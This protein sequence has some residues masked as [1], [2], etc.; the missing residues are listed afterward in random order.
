M[1]RLVLALVLASCAAPQKK[2]EAAPPP[3][4]EEAIAALFSQAYAALS[5]CSAA[6]AAELV[7]SG[8]QAVTFADAFS[9]HTEAEDDDGE[10]VYPPVAYT[11]L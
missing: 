4:P 5:E 2:K 6:E 1:R 10:A 7:G 9:V 3:S 8:E 11:V